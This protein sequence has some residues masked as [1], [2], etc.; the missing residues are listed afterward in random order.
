MGLS[1]DEVIELFWFAQSFQQYYGPGVD[2]G[3]QKVSGK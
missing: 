2:S 1:L 3:P